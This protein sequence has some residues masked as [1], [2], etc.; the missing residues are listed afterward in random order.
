LER[1][2]LPSSF[3][4]I[5]TPSGIGTRCVMTRPAPIPLT[6]IT[7]ENI[8][9]QRLLNPEGDPMSPRELRGLHPQPRLI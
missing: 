2:I 6:A 1:D 4:I 7:E 8:H 3:F 9:S 5:R